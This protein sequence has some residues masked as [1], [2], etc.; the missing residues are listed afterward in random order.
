[1]KS[2]I[3]CINEQLNTQKWVAISITTS[4]NNGWDYGK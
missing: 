2:V 3:S 4:S 1:M